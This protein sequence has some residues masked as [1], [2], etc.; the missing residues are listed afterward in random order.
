MKTFAQPSQVLLDV[1]GG[2]IYAG[3]DLLS[4][5]QWSQLDSLVSR[6]QGHGKLLKASEDFAKENDV[7]GSY[8]PEWRLS[9]LIKK[10]LDPQGTFSPGVLPGRV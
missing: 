4:A 5:D 6:C 3:F 7:F 10:A 1:A 8:R 9:H 2:R